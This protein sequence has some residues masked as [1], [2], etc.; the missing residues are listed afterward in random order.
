MALFLF[1]RKILAGEPIDVFNHGNHRRD[2]TY[3]DD[4]VEGVIRV[5]DQPAVPNLEWNGDTPDPATSNAPHRLYNIGNNNWVE[6]SRYIE[7]LEDCLGR[8]AEKN[9]LPL[10][11][12]DVP[13]TYADIDDL[14]STIGYRPNTSIEVGVRRFVD[15]YRDYYGIE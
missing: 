2:F 5:L 6:L 10:Q 1:T 13:D 15:W 14:V 9:L 4:I 12:G 8:K 11:P 3:V 7:V